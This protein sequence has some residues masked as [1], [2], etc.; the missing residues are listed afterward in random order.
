MDDFASVPFKQACYEQLKEQGY[1]IVAT[2]PYAHAKKPSEISADQK[3]AL[4]FGNETAG[5]SPYALKYA[6]EFLT[7]P[8][9]M[10]GATL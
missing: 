6:D 2:S 4:V 8:M 9:L 3:T 10:H 5:L 1:K 7:I